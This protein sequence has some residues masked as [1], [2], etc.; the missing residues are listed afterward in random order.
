M[1]QEHS[2]E[3]HTDGLADGTY[4]LN[5]DGGIVAAPNQPEGEAAMG[6]LITSATGDLVA[7]GSARLGWCRDH[8]VAEFQA[9]IL[10][11]SMAKHLGIS[12]LHVRTDS[13]LVHHTM[14]DEWRL[15]P[16]H[17]RALR[18]QA[19]EVLE[20]FVSVEISWVPRKDNSQADKLAGK[21][22]GPLRPKPPLKPDVAEGA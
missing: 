10:G 15:K 22:L 20:N 6:A 4:F 8:H 1:M 13:E 17:L 9:L 19:S 5:T 2:R 14:K 18:D 21:L 16:A 7:E 11:L 3:H 12:R